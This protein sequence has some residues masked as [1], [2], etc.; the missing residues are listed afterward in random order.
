MES[1]DQEVQDVKESESETDEQKEEN[2]AAA[3]LAELS[4]AIL[5]ESGQKWVQDQGVTHNTYNMYN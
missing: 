2:A 3:L 4:Q 1:S 5:A